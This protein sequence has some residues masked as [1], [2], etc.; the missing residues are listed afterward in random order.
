MIP[1]Q[2]LAEA[3]HLQAVENNPLDAEDIALFERFEREGFTPDER[4]P[5]IL[6]H[7]DVM[8]P[9]AE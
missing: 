9:A 7:V 5:H 4:R 8:V 2:K 1:Q 3:L 6:A